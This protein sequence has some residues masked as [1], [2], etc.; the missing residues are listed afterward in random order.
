MS[1]CTPLERA[2]L[3]GGDDSRTGEDARLDD[4]LVVLARGFV[5]LAGACLVVPLVAGRGAA[6][7]GTVPVGPTEDARVD[8]LGGGWVAM[9]DEA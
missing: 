2:R 3:R 6:L 7:A 4:R 9:T 1:D 5:G 8:R